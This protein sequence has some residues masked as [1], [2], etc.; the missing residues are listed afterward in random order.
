MI[1]TLLYKL[2]E[3]ILCVLG[4]AFLFVIFYGPLFGGCNCE[5]TW[6][7]ADG[8]RHRAEILAYP[9][10]ERDRIVSRA[11][12]DPSLVQNVSVTWDV[13]VLAWSAILAVV[14]VVALCIYLFRKG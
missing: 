10:E 8:E 7:T 14:P 12:R 13:G 9:W 11:L 2:K 5:V 4:A 3:A 6:K 1:R